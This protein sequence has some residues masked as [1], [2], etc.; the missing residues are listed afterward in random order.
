M[1]NPAIR[2]DSAP[3]SALWKAADALRLLARYLGVSIRGQMQ[4][5]ASFVMS[6]LG[7]FFITGIEFLGVWA[8]FDRFGHIEGWTLAEVSLFYGV[9]NVSFSFADALSMGFDKFSVSVKSGEFDRMLLRPRT[10]ALQLSG[11][12]FALR[13]AGRLAQG[14]IILVLASQYLEVEWSAARL[15]LLVATILAGAA[16]FYGLFVLQAVIAFF[17][18]E[19]LELMNTLTYGGVQTAQYP[20]TIYGQGFRRFFTFVIPLA[21]VTY[22]P[23]LAILERSD[24][25]GAPLWLCWLS[26]LAG[27]LFLTGA[28]G[29]WSFGVRHYTST[30]S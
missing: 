15:F 23:M 13:R 25:L 10:T 18:I 29:A 16:L 9:V 19:T 6:A 24:P 4:Y 11:Q 28:F 7:Q 3:P 21:A 14:L 27:P 22:Y 1:A 8:L 12:E 20:I 26:P 2:S 17:T 30:G 5:R